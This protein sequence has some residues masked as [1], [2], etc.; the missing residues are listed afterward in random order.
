MT[1]SVHPIDLVKFGTRVHKRVESQLEAPSSFAP[2]YRGNVYVLAM[3][4]ENSYGDRA[5]CRG[6]IK[7]GLDAKAEPN[8]AWIEIACP[9]TAGGLSIEHALALALLRALLTRQA[10]VLAIDRD[11]TQNML[12]SLQSRPWSAGLRDAF[13]VDLRHVTEA[14]N[15]RKPRPLLVA[16]EPLQSEATWTVDMV[17]A[18]R[19]LSA[20][21]HVPAVALRSRGYVTD[22]DSTLLVP[23]RDPLARA[24]DF[25]SRMQ[26][27]TRALWESLIGALNEDAGADQ[28]D[29]EGTQR[30]ARCFDMLIE[31]KLGAINSRL[32]AILHP[33][34]PDMTKLASRLKDVVSAAGREATHLAP[35][36]DSSDELSRA[37]EGNA[38]PVRQKLASSEIEDVCSRTYFLLILEQFR[39][40]LVAEVVNDRE[41]A[42]NLFR[43]QLTFLA[44]QRLDQA[45]ASLLDSTWMTRYGSDDHLSQLF[46]SLM[47][48]RVPAEPLTRVPVEP[49]SR[50]TFHGPYLVNP[51]QSVD[52]LVQY[53]D[54]VFGGALPYV[55]TS[56]QRAW[57]LWLGEL[58]TWCDKEMSATRARFASE[59]RRKAEGASGHNRWHDSVKEAFDRAPERLKSRPAFGTEVPVVEG[60]AEGRAFDDQ[61]RSWY[62]GLRHAIESRSE[63]D[64]VADLAERRFVERLPSPFDALAGDKCSV[65]QL[66]D[67]APRLLACV[68]VYWHARPRVTKDSADCSSAVGDSDSSS[69]PVPELAEG[70][71]VVQRHLQQW[72]DA[73]LTLV[74]T[75]RGRVRFELR[76]AYAR[77]LSALGDQAKASEQIED[78]SGKLDSLQRSHV[79]F[80]RAALCEKTDDGTPLYERAIELYRRVAARAREQG[81]NELAFRALTGAVRCGVLWASKRDPRLRM[82]F[83]ANAGLLLSAERSPRVAR[84]RRQ[85]A[86]VFVS[87]TR[88]DFPGFTDDK[89]PRESVIGELFAAVQ[90]QIESCDGD[91]ARVRELLW[92]DRFAIDDD[93]QEFSPLLLMGLQ[94]AAAVVVLFSE[95]YFRSY[96]C[97]YEL[98]LAATLARQGSVQLS[99]AY[100]E[101]GS[102]YSHG[103]AA[104]AIEAHY[105]LALE[106]L[107]RSNLPGDEHKDFV[108]VMKEVKS[109]TTQR[110]PRVSVESLQD[111][112]KSSAEDHIG[113][114][115][116]R[117]T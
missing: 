52:A 88:P 55:N 66:L 72:R 99:Y 12:A 21:A 25:H 82:L 95:N 18:V 62:D 30:V 113:R 104:S 56:T 9:P 77:V 46:Q 105:S 10:S 28:G 43:L 86:P 107:S 59:K 85:V 40:A 1:E 38:K 83:A 70:W 106:A 109:F 39:P 78:L 32:A 57:E 75:S 44:D 69:S 100:C 79:D 67:V 16:W 112:V 50:P 76:L 14:V 27:E 48:T 8:W 22:A 89:P 49:N 41:G 23:Q 54:F 24:G 68:D 90:E 115:L 3:T 45:A 110:L 35:R 13:E 61:L 26:R 6:A 33:V 81:A 2:D 7:E 111:F 92:V 20:A 71:Q 29:D 73:Y 31:P 114:L 15:S 51:F 101:K 117:V 5:L 42:Y 116:G 65:A 87:Y 91:G 94:N 80:A 4:G 102:L 74:D 37:A 17:A 36:S 93:M 11:R 98:R 58:G 97:R 103:Q 64:Q 84:L 53:A 96:W 60:Q 108:E 47:L 63:E 34:T 19:W